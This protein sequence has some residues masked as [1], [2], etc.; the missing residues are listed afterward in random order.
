MVV[1]TRFIAGI[2]VPNTPIINASIALAHQ[3]LPTFA[4]NHVIRAWLNGQAIV[5]K[6]P[7]ANLSTFDQEAF[8]V[9]AILHDLG[10]WVKF[11]LLY[12]DS[13]ELISFRNKEIMSLNTRFEVDGADQAREFLQQNGGGAWDKHRQQLVWESIAIH[14]TASIALYKELEVVLVAAGTA[15]DV[16]GPEIAKVSF[17]DLIT[18]T[19]TE[20]D[21]ITKEF[22]SKGQKALFMDVAIHLCQFKPETT[23]DNII[24]D[25]GDK[26]VQNYTRVGHR[27]VDVMEAVMPS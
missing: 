13:C 5:N 7:A 15:T 9:G 19:Q 17:G 10:W 14:S 26:Y 21:Q 8:G 1:F 22:P 6:L 2:Q 23:Y 20:Y 4:Y 24:G 16:L 3:N 11:Y 18:V 27:L 25:F 12:V